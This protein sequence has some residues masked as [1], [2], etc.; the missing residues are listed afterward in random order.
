MP[1]GVKLS[2]GWLIEQCGWKQ[3]PHPTVGVYEHQALVVINRGGATGAEVLAFAAEV[4]NSVRTRF[5]VELK[6]EVNVIE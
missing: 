1:D 2:A 3:N 5:G 6:M 4:C